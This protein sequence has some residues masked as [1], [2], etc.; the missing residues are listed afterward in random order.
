MSGNV[1]NPLRHAWAERRRANRLSYAAETIGERE[2]CRDIAGERNRLR[3]AAGH[4]EQRASVAEAVVSGERGR[5][6]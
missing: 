4:A 5:W 2:L 1:C 3:E 6:R